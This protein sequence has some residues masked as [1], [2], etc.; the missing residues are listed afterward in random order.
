MPSRRIV[1]VSL[2]QDEFDQR[3]TEV[4][5]DTSGSPTDNES[6]IGKAVNGSAVASVA[7]LQDDILDDKVSITFQF[8][9][10]GQLIGRNDF[11]AVDAERFGFG[12]GFGFGSQSRDVFS[13][14]RLD[15][16]D[17]ESA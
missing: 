17:P 14:C 3:G 9:V 1:A 15:H 4:R 11:V 12:F 2:Q 13:G 6:P 16:R 10:R 5:I 8:G 7:R